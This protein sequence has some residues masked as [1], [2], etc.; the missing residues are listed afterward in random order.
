MCHHSLN[1]ITGYVVR[2]TY[3]DDRP[4]VDV[5]QFIGAHKYADAVERA[6][7]ERTAN[8]GGYAVV[9]TFYACGCRGA[10]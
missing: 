3:F 5:A 9:D 4:H 2:R 1:T 10:A 8:P 7:A 6:R